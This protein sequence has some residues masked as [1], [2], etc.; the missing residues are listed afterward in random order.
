MEHIDA[1]QNEMLICG[2][3]MGYADP[4]ARINSYHPLRVP[5]EEFSRW[6]D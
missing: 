6:L 4:S 2:M 1:G 5:V 3:S